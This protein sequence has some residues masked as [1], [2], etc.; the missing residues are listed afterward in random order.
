MDFLDWQIG[1]KIMVDKKIQPCTK[2]KHFVWCEFGKQT[3]HKITGTPCN[4]FEFG[5]ENNG[6]NG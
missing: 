3:F 1:V 4:E 6:N 2:C 5:G